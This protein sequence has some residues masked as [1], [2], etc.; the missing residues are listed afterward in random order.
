MV[1]FADQ[2]KQDAEAN[3]DISSVQGSNWFKFEEGDNQFRILVQP[4]VLYERFKVGICYTDCGYTGTPKYLTW[5]LDKKDNTVK[6]FKLPY[7]LSETLGAWQSD[8]DYKFDKFPMPYDMKVTAVGAGTKEVKYSA[9]P[10]PVKELT[11]EEKITVTSKLMDKNTLM[12]EAIIEKMKEK[13]IAK[14]KE[15]GKPDIKEEVNQA[16]K[17]K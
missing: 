15:E 17:T 11:E 13:Q 7:G 10:K 16:P 9:V 14:H 12:P 2:L 4:I 1:N 8:E 3:K 6:L 5:I